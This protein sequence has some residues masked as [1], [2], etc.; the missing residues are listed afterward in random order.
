MSN[1]H[2]VPAGI[3]HLRADKAL[4]L[5]HPEHSRAAFHRAFDAG[6]VKRGGQAISRDTSVAGGDALEYSFPPATDVSRLIACPTRFTSP[7]SNAR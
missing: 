3:R 5:A 6:L 4:A 7:A 2:I 1:L